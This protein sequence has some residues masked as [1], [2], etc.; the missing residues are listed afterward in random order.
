MLKVAVY[1]LIFE[2]DVKHWYKSNAKAKIPYGPILSENVN[3]NFLFIGE[4]VASSLSTWR[5]LHCYDRIVMPH[6]N[7]WL[8]EQA[9]S[10]N[11]LIWGSR[12]E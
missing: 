7:D 12:S 3:W 10:V 5:Y 9:E 8:D 11:G 6:S 4:I 2:I 1:L